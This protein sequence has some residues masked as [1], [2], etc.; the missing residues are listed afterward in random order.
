[1]MHGVGSIHAKDQLEILH[2]KTSS[3]NLDM[4]VEESTEV[5]SI[6]GVAE[7]ETK[8][9]G[10]GRAVLHRRTKEKLKTLVRQAT[11]HPN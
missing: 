6:E 5:E 7:S 1:M 3:K 4:L 9:E 10:D 11:L 2:S 8:T